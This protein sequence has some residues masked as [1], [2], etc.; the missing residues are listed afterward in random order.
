[1]NRQKLE[2]FQSLFSGLLFKCDDIIQQLG[3]SQSFQ[4]LFSGLLFKYRLA[5]P[6]MYGAD[7]FQSLFSGLLFKYGADCRLFRQSEIV[8]IPFFR[9]SF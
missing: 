9:S 4:S 8:S 5:I 6:A 3:F 1:M 2:A 7:W